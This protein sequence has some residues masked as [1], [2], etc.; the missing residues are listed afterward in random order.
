LIDR[1]IVT[2]DEVEIRYVIPTSP[3]SEHVRFCHLRSDY[4]G[5]PQARQVL[6]IRT[7]RQL[8]KVHLG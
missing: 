3:E 8:A 7:S 2:D 4:L 5:D 6:E 1:V